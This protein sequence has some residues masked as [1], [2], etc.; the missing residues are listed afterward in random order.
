MNTPN[1]KKE[2]NILHVY[3]QSHIKNF[4]HSGGSK[5][6]KIFNDFFEN[7]S[8]NHENC[9]IEK[10]SDLVL[11]TKLKSM[12]LS[13]YS[14]IFIHY[15]MFPLSMLYVKIFYPKLKIVS[16]SHNAELP[17]WLQ[18]SYLELKNYRFKKSLKFFFIAL[19]NGFGELVMG[20]FA[21]YILAITEWEANFYWKKFAFSKILYAPYY[22]SDMEKFEN[23]ELKKNQCICLMSPNYSSFLHDSANNFYKLV[24]SVYKST[25]WNFVITG[26]DLNLDF[27]SDAPIEKLGFVDDISSLYKQSKSIAVLTTYGYGF[28][29]KILEAAAYGCW[30]LVPMKNFSRI[31][32]NVRPFCISVDLE[33]PLSFKEALRLAK[34][35]IPNFSQQNDELKSQFYESLQTSL[36]K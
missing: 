21:R 15:P 18:H 32:I 34:K 10:K 22:L 14:H 13:L 35:N 36:L 11:F 4:L 1:I 3:P 23:N 24:S 5:G 28:K 12:D 31:P 7:N 30:S 20:V 2:P 19:R 16:R 33:S 9:I 8:I 6:I 26:E 27:I 17:H 29:T 25:E